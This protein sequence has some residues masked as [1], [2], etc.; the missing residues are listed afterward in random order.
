MQAKSFSMLYPCSFCWWSVRLVQVPLD[1][2]SC[3][4]STSLLVASGVSA[5]V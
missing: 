3:G 5:V 1:E 2:L 4:I